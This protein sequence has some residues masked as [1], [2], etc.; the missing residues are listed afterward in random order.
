MKTALQII[1]T[2]AKAL[3]KSHP[4]TKWVNLVKK[5]GVEYR[6]GKI[7]KVSSASRQ[8]GKSNSTR[9]KALKA[10]APGKRVVKYAGGKSTVYY[11]RRKNRSDKPGSLTGI[12]NSRLIGEVKARIEGNLAK[13]MVKHYLETSKIK[14][15]QIAKEIQI[16]KSELKRIK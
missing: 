14:K 4:N 2:R 11:E 10:K 13:K 12:S 6:A 3:K 16:L 8:T 7:G 15:R 9:D 5:A 1:T